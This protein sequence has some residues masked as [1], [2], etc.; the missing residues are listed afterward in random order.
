MK[1]LRIYNHI[2]Y[3]VMF[4]SIFETTLSHSDFEEDLSARGQGVIITSIAAVG[5]IGAI[6]HQYWITSPWQSDL[7]EMKERYPYVQ[8]WY[9]YLIEKYPKVHFNTKQLLCLKSSPN[10]YQSWKYS[11]NQIYCSLDLLTKI[12]NLYHEK[13]KGKKLTDEDLFFL[14]VQEFMILC[15]AGAI[16]QNHMIQRYLYSFEIV[17]GCEFL[18]ILYK[19]YTDND[20]QK[21]FSSQKSLRVKE[22]RLP[23]DYTWDDVV[24]AKMTERNGNLLGAELLIAIFLCASIYS[25]QKPQEYAFVC[26]HADIEVLEQTLLFLKEFINRKEEDINAYQFS[27]TVPEWYYHICFNPGESSSS[28][29]ISIIRNEIKRR[30]NY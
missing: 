21:Y 12:N 27:S 28:D 14:N 26:K 2:C 6:I 18:R 19:E 5:F 10:E 24:H 17:L 13:V 11:F 3:I 30:K 20:A 4:L 25:F 22:D 16:E 29:R 9:N 23:V 15:Q 7:L 8:N 1:R